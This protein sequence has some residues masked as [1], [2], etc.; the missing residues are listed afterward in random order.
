[1]LSTKSQATV[2]FDVLGQLLP[3]NAGLVSDAMLARNILWADKTADDAPK[4]NNN[5]KKYIY[6]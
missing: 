6:K 1:M 4:Y 5:K 3:A 2:L